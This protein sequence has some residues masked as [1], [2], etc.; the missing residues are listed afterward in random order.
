M[1]F[2]PKNGKPE[3]FTIQQIEAFRDAYRDDEPKR[4][5]GV[6]MAVSR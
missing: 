5:E 3:F 4:N 1:K 6:V 2:M